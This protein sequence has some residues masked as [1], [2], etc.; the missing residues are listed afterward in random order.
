MSTSA[1]I[2]DRMLGADCRRP[3]IDNLIT[4]L[5]QLGATHVFTYDALSDKS[6]AQQVKQWT[7]KSVSLS[8]IGLYRRTDYSPPSQYA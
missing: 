5:A 2:F 3:D 4:S 7:S 8:A 6:L 1:A